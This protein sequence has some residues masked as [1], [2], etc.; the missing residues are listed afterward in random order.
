MNKYLLLMASVAFLG[1]VE[2][3]SAAG[4]KTKKS[5][6]E[7]YKERA[8]AHR[9]VTHA[10][11]V[12]RAEETA[13]EW[14]VV[15]AALENTN[16]KKNN[17]LAYD[18]VQRSLKRSETRVRNLKEGR[19]FGRKSRRYARPTSAETKRKSEAFKK[20]S[21]AAKK[22]GEDKAPAK[23]APASAHKP[24]LMERMFGTQS[25]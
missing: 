23:R 21:E 16:L 1:A 7:S 10:E 19:T 15:A 8:R 13:K 12:A 3:V 25:K 17:P 18:R 22:R 5:G 24:T 6:F 4:E 20:R 9:R 11:K 2:N 14:S